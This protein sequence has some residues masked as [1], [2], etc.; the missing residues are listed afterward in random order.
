MIL[1]ISQYFEFKYIFNMDTI[2]SKIYFFPEI[3]YHVYYR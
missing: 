2:N 3:L 1:C